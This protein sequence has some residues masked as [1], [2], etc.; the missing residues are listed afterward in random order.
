MAQVFQSSAF[1]IVKS[2]VSQATTAGSTGGPLP[3]DSSGNVPRYIRVA[4][5]SPAC[6]R[7]GAGAQT[8]VISDMQI[9]PGDSAVLSVPLGVTNFACV[10]VSAA[11]VMQ[12]S[13]LENQ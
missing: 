11:G 2:G 4:A 9:Q 12:I 8:A 5:T 1:T 6:F 10:Q 3:L 13:P 7:M